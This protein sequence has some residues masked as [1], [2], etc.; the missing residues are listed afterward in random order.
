M[1]FTANKLAINMSQ[2]NPST[3][4]WTNVE[5]VSNL[6]W[7]SIAYGNGR[8]V[9]IGLSSN[10]SAYSS[11]GISWT[12]VEMPNYG[13][14]SVAYGNGV[15]VAFNEDLKISGVSA[16]G[17][18]WDTYSLPSLPVSPNQDWMEISFG[19]GI[20]IIISS[21]NRSAWSSDGISWNLVTIQAPTASLFWRKIK[22][23]GSLFIAIQTGE[24]SSYLT[25]TNG[26]SWSSRSFPLTKEWYDIAYGNG[27]I[28]AV[29]NSDF[30]KTALYSNDGI[31]W[32]QTTTSESLVYPSVVYGNG[33]FMLVSGY[34]SY[35]SLDGITWVNCVQPNIDRADIYI[36]YGAGRFLIGAIGIYSYSRLP[37]TLPPAPYWDP[38]FL[39]TLEFWYDASD[40]RFIAKSGSSVTSVEDKS[41]NGHT[42]SVIRAGRVGPTIGTRKLNGLNVFE[43][44][45]TSPNNQVLE[46]DS[47]SYNQSAAPLNVA[48]VVR[49]DTDAFD[50]Q[51]FLF[52]GTD[53]T[54]DRLAVRRSSLNAL[55]ILSTNTIGTPQGSFIEGVNYLVIAKFNSTNSEI[56]LN[57][58]LI[59][60]GNIGTVYFSSI[61]IGANEL[62]DQSIEGFIAEVLAFSDNTKQEIIE[63]Y[64]AWK[65]GIQANLPS[66]HPYK[67]SPPQ[68]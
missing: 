37:D 47:F 68:V 15:F 55:Q 26:I 9:S 45:P 43:Y 34:Y 30:Y 24:T 2:V 63:G 36:F 41:G 21:Y 14:F 8:F 13:W 5:S 28:V 12:E 33:R 32:S 31:N 52:T 19:N 40:P 35:Y 59:N 60:S 25:T 44:A 54:V 39:T 18:T 42:L 56:R 65:W 66:N 4:Y 27:T 57:G 62:E 49:C 58:A 16:D 53:A 61:N 17:I 20:F 38:S 3:G 48:M 10:K 50:D 22:Y 1:S 64:L 11:D 67:N 46:N 23:V 29:P 7:S 51:D 6:N